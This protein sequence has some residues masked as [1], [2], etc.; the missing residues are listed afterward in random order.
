MEL[1]LFNEIPDRAP[2]PASVMPELNVAY[3]P[4]VSSFNTTLTTPAIASDPYWA[5][6]P[7]L[8]ISTRLIASIGIAEM[9][10]ADSPRLG[11]VCVYTNALKFF[12]LQLMRINVLLTPIFLISQGSSNAVASFT[13]VWAVLNE[14]TRYWSILSNVFCPVWA[15]S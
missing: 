7:S 1:P 11:E 8:N 3:P 13:G 5:D 2:S 15:T 9:S 10:T 14:G 6:A 12:R 4:C